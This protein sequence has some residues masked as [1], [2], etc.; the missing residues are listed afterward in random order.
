IAEDPAIDVGNDMSTSGANSTQHWHSEYPEW[1]WPSDSVHPIGHHGLQST[2]SHAEVTEDGLTTRY[3]LN[4][5]SASMVIEDGLL[6]FSTYLPA[7]ADIDSYQFSVDFTYLGSDLNNSSIPGAWDGL[8]IG[9]AQGGILTNGWNMMMYG[10]KVNFSIPQALEFQEFRYLYNAT[11]KWRVDIH[12][13]MFSY[14]LKENVSLDPD[15][16]AHILSEQS[17]IQNSTMVDIPVNFSAERGSVHIDGAME[18]LHLIEN[19]VV[20]VP[21][22][23]VPDGSVYHAVTRHR[24]LENLTFTDIEL[25]MSPIRSPASSEVLM[26]IVDPDAETPTFE[27]P[28]GQGLVEWDVGNTTVLRT[29]GYWEV[30]WVWSTTWLW[31]DHAL[32]HFMTEAHD[33]A[34]T[35]LGPAV[36]TVGFSAGNAVENDLE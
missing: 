11:G 8:D 21:E 5:Q 25:M 29:D 4:S 13:M 26:R 12:R 15:D 24:H 32:I 34:S 14:D 9:Q 33:A 30:E 17:V 3:D 36:E 2:I 22:A 7:S 18:W 6:N 20:E 10:S 1:A 28:L 27:Q 16:M 23:M 31:D 35:D 19:E